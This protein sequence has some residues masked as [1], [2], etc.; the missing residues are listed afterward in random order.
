MLTDCS[1]KN[2]ASRV[3]CIV[4]RPSIPCRS[5]PNRL[6]RFSF[7]ASAVLHASAAAM[8]FWGA[9]DSKQGLFEYSVIQ[10]KPLTIVLATSKAAPPPPATIDVIEPIDVAVPAKPKTQN[11]IQPTASLAPSKLMR[12]RPEIQHP[13]EVASPSKLPSDEFQR[14]NPEP[15]EM[16]RRPMSV[17]SPADLQEPLPFKPTRQVQSADLAVAKV[18]TEAV[19]IPQRDRSGASIDQLPRSLRSNTPPN[20]PLE[21]LQ[22]G[23][24][25]RVLIR[26][27]IEENGRVATASIHSTSGSTSLDNAALSAVRDWRFEPAQRGGE[28]AAHEVI[29]PVRFSIRRS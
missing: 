29:I 24:E 16:A 14:S 19:A 17:D 21:A 5:A 23:I 6:V 27:Y 25:G 20:Y 1:P 2:A 12:N 18:S 10:G 9:F 26:V 8:A 7:A 28:P 3:D 15:T 11:E 4:I 22:A 13:T